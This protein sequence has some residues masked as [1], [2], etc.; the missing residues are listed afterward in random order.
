MDIKN[1]SIIGV[2]LIGGSFALALKKYGFK[3]RIT[4]IGRSE[5]NLVHAKDRGIIDDHS[6][7]HAEGVRSADLVM[8][9]APVGQFSTIAEKIKGSLKPGAIVTDAGSVKAKVIKEM[10]EHMPANVL[11]VPAHPIAGKETQG[12]DGADADLFVKA[13]CIFTPSEHTDKNAMEKV[14]DLWRTTGAEPTVMTPDKHDRVFAAVSHVPHVVA[15]AL[16]NSILDSDG[17]LLNNSGA[18]LK[19]MTRIAQSPAAL[20]KDICS[21]NRVNILNGLKNF[22]SAISKMTDL[23]EGSDWEGLEQEFNRANRGRTTIE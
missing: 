18:G 7:D 4:G 3:G 15:Y 8:L 21:Y 12:I 19:D 11:F 14:M 23:I 13:K 6:T 22:S 17:N 5:E 9:A 10:E 20:W 16:I 2:G 1:I